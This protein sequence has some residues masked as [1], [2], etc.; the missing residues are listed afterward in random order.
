MVKRATMIPPTVINMNAAR[1]RKRG[2]NQEG[3]RIGAAIRSGLKKI[4]TNSGVQRAAASALGQAAA[5]VGVPQSAIQAGT[6]FVEGKIQAGEAR[7]AARQTGSGSKDLGQGGAGQEGGAIMRQSRRGMVGGRVSK[8][9]REMGVERLIGTRYQVFDGT[10][11]KMKQGLTKK[12]F[13]RRGTRVISL[14]A[15][16]NGKRNIAKN[17]KMVPFKKGKAA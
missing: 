13:F 17:P 16:Q 14:K 12:D 4:V 1:A 10:A 3:G 11:Y 2:G 8:K 15:S 9:A 5:A 7:R 6:S